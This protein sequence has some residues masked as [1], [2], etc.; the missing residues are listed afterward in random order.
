MR[1]FGAKKSPLRG[2]L[3][4]PD[5]NS[6]KK[7][8]A[9]N[10]RIDRRVVKWPNSKQARTNYMLINSPKLI[11]NAKSR[12]EFNLNITFKYLIFKSV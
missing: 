11:K 5:E 1:I 9:A 12:A 3:S 6:L 8:E 4:C 10:I 2:S 7:N